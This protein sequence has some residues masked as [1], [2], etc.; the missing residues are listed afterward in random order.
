MTRREIQAATRLADGLIAEMEG[1]QALMGKQQGLAKRAEGADSEVVPMLKATATQPTAPTEALDNAMF[2]KALDAVSAVT[3]ITDVNE[4]AGI[5]MAALSAPVDT[6]G[7]HD[8]AVMLAK[9][10]HGAPGSVPVTDDDLVGLVL[11]TTRLEKAAQAGRDH[12][13]AQLQDE[14]SR[15]RRLAEPAG[16]A[17]TARLAKAAEVAAPTVF[18]CLREIYK[19]PTIEH[20]RSNHVA[21]FD[22]RPA[23]RELLKAARENG[24][25]GGAARLREELAFAEARALTDTPSG[26]FPPSAPAA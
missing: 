23:L 24:D 9:A 14:A 12:L 25:T 26:T 5:M 6:Y 20:P 17:E 16:H 11:H 3:G 21:Y 2:T 4:L 19:H 10:A 8:T 7:E 15:A 13:V 1:L 18:D 22:R